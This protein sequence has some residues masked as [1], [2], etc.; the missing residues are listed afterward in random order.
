MKA[1]NILATRDGNVKLADFGI[2]QSL[3]D[4]F[5]GDIAGSYDFTLFNC[6]SVLTISPLWMAPEVCLRKKYD[7]KVDIWSL[8]I[9]AIELVDGDVC[10]HFVVSAL[11]LT[12]LVAK[13]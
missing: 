8:G 5:L 3:A 6:F 12:L 2:S 10:F 7:F 4:S 9:T 1:A 11:L 13:L